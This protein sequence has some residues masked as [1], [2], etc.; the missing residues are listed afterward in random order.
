MIIVFIKE[1]ISKITYRIYKSNYKK[2]LVNNPVSKKQ[3]NDFLK[4]SF[5]KSYKRFNPIRYLPGNEFQRLKVLYNFLAIESLSELTGK[6]IQDLS[7]EYYWDLK[8]KVRSQALGLKRKELSKAWGKENVALWNSFNTIKFQSRIFNNICFFGAE[9]LDYGCSVGCA[10]FLASTFNTKSHTV[11]D[12]P[13]YAL[14]VAERSLK[15][16]GIKTNKIPIED[17]ALPTVYE[18]NK[19]DIIFC[20]HVL[21]H[22]FDPVQTCKNLINALKPNGVILYTYY[23]ASSPDGY[24]TVEGLEKR[25]EALRF[26]RSKTKTT[27]I[28]GLKPYEIAIKS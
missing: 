2:F 22:T 12:V 17:P 11:S 28:K 6:S 13:G 4:N 15:K 7:N 19:F 20:L 26:L 5:F 9:V 1:L 18:E 16:L 27:K 3:Y 10:S 21:E 23:K 8:E 25:N 24:N 14:D